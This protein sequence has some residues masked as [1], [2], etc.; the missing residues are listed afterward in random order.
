MAPRSFLVLLS[1][2][3]GVAVIFAVITTIKYVPPT[4]HARAVTQLGGL[5]SQPV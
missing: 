2:A 3:F 4:T 5:E 1:I